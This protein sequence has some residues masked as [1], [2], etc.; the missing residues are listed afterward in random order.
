M[1]LMWE[2]PIRL[3]GWALLCQ[4]SCGLYWSHPGDKENK[5]GG[6]RLKKN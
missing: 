6:T 1:K 3:S 2:L 5:E 4:G